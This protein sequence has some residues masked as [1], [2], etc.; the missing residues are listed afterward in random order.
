[1][2]SKVSA[3]P[4]STLRV[5]AHQH[6][7]HYQAAQYA[8]IDERHAALRRHFQPADLKPLLEAH[9]I[10]ASIAVQARQ[11]AEE[12]DALLAL[13]QGNR[14]IAGVVGWADLRSDG[15][16]AQLEQWCQH[17]PFVG[18]RH[19]IQDEP[20]PARL[21]EDPAFA[22]G[23]GTLQD[24]GLTY[25]LLVREQDLAAAADFCRR[26]DRHHL[27]VDHFAKPDVRRQSPLAWADR[28][29]PLAALP[30]VSCKLSGL[31]TEADW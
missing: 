15:L 31:V 30:H 17:P 24:R 21:M 3:E 9:R 18:L 28:V 4:S 7:W 5:D 23:I 14:W 8:W 25:D 13:A 19:L 26:H 6:F 11:Q 20:S 27:I 2:S 10:D 22:Q 29:A 1:M 12:T 16:D